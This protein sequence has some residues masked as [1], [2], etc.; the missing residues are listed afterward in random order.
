MSAPIHVGAT[1]GSHFNCAYLAHHRSLNW[2]CA[3]QSFARGDDLGIQGAEA[4]RASEAH[5]RSHGSLNPKCERRRSV[6]CNFPA[7]IDWRG[8]IDRGSNTAIVI[9]DV[10][11]DTDA[12]RAVQL[13]DVKW[14]VAAIDDL[15]AGWANDGDRFDRSRLLAAT[16][17]PAQSSGERNKCSNTGAGPIAVE[18]HPSPSRAGLDNR[19]LAEAAEESIL[20]GGGHS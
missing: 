7:G 6:R 16:E 4:R 19:T 1:Y 3:R 15:D 11:T 14:L 5:F 17:H 2:L 10:A 8:L 9:R 18:R 20:G 12:P 13:I